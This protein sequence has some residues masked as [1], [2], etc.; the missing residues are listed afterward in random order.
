MRLYFVR[1]LH[2]LS[3]LPISQ[4]PKCGNLLNLRDNH[5]RLIRSVEPVQYTLE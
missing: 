1:I 3:N 4:S 5:P 2:H